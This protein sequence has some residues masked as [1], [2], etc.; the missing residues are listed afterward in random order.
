MNDLP[1]RFCPTCGHVGAPP[2]YESDCCPESENVR[3]VPQSVALYE[4]AKLRHANRRE[5]CA[6]QAL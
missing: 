6:Q 4:Q 3:Y 5:P 1:I 2:R